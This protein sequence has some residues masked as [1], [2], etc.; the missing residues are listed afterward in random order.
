M[1]KFHKYLASKS[2]VE[3]K[4]EIDRYLMEDV[5]KLNAN[6]DILNWWKVNS[7]KFPILAQI[8]QDVLSI[9][10]TTA[11]SKSAFSTEGRVFGTFSKFVGSKYN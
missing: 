4:L 7:T 11:A 1:N 9:P 5:E 10:I 8:T 3:S 6:F 2:D